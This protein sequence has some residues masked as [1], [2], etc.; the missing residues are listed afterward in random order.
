MPLSRHMPAEVLHSDILLHGHCQWPTEHLTASHCC[1]VDCQ[2]PPSMSSR[3]MPIV[4]LGVTALHGCGGKSVH[5]Q[6][7]GLAALQSHLGSLFW[8]SRFRNPQ[9]QYNN[10][11]R[12][13][14]SVVVSSESGPIVFLASPRLRRCL[15]ACLAASNGMVLR[16]TTACDT[17][18]QHNAHSKLKPAESSKHHACPTPVFNATCAGSLLNRL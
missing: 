7:A 8:P 10:L 14:T 2:P 11:P 18:E 4:L 3:S 17:A 16:H 15:G 9:Q 13:P 6:L 12:C 5:Q 1:Y